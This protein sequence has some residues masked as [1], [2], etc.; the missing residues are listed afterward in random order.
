MPLRCPK[1]VRKLTGLV[2]L[3][4]AI[5]LASGDALAAKRSRSSGK[6]VSSSQKKRAKASKKAGRKGRGKY[7]AKRGRKGRKRAS[8]S[9]DIAELP[10]AP[11]G[12]GAGISNERVSEIQGALV[13]RGYLEGPPTGEWD[14]KTQDAVRNFQTDNRLPA[15]GQPSAHFLKRLGVSKRPADGY[16]TP[17]SSSAD[18]DKHKDKEKE[19]DKKAPPGTPET[20]PPT[21]P[22]L[23]GPSGFNLEAAADP[24]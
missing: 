18:S 22:L 1:L 16:A 8:R 4:L 24:L 19:K 5:V 9:Y 20:R 2:A 12:A 14:D 10:Q 13:K 3:A 21:N 15:T 11:R 6:K 7:A 17:V 23:D